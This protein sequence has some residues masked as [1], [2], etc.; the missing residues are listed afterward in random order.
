MFP[1]HSTDFNFYLCLTENPNNSFEFGFSLKLGPKF[2]LNI[3]HNCYFNINFSIEIR[4]RIFG[5]FSLSWGLSP[6]SSGRYKL[7]FLVFLGSISVSYLASLHLC[8]YSSVPRNAGAISKLVPL[9]A[10]FR[11]V[12]GFGVYLSTLSL[13][14]KKVTIT[15]FHRPT[16]ISD[17]LQL[18]R[19]V[20]LSCYQRCESRAISCALWPFAGLVLLMQGSDFRFQFYCAHFHFAAGQGDF[21]H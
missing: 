2:R 21:W 3:N 15:V 17:T 16:Y 20:R 5:Y 19:K 1:F 10:S 7:D 6:Y 18:S 9:S 8:L 14:E 4:L 13:P 12:D 11:K